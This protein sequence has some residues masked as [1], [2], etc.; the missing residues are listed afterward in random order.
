MLSMGGG[1]KLKGGNNGILRKNI[2]AQNMK[3]IRR[4]A[5]GRNMKKC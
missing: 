4:E 3:K 5:R 2:Y 1:G